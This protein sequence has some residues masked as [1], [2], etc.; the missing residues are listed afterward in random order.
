MLGVVVS[1]KEI[2]KLYP[3]IGSAS[4]PLLTLGLLIMNSRAE[5]VGKEFRNHRTTDA[6]LPRF[7]CLDRLANIGQLNTCRR[8]N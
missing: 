7:L 4:I 6:V 3:V 2:Q 5:W 8:K 1:F